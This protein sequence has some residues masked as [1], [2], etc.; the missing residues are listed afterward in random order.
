MVVLVVQVIVENMVV[1]LIVVK[2]E[3]HQGISYFYLMMLQHIE[4]L[5]MKHHQNQEYKMAL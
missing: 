1:V 5:Y 3:E 4:V 2:I